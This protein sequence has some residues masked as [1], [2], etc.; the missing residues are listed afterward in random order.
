MAVETYINPLLNPTGVSTELNLSYMV[1]SLRLLG[2]T[3]F[4][5]TVVLWTTAPTKKR[6]NRVAAV[7]AHFQNWV[8]HMGLGQS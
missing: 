2:G 7:A 5:L 8:A 4:Y 1:P 6:K 3:G